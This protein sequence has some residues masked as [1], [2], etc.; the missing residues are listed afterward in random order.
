MGIRSLGRSVPGLPPRPPVPPVSQGWTSAP[1]AGKVVHW[2][3]AMI[4]VLT[5]AGGV[6]LILFGVRFLRKGLDRLFGARLGHWMRRLADRR[7]KAFLAGLG[8][9]IVA[10]SSTTVSVL[11]V[12]TVAA[13]HMTARQMLAVMFGADIGLTITV[14]LI[15]L[16]IEQYAPIVILP[17]VV[18]FQFCKR[19]PTRGIGQVLISLGMIFM[20]ID[21]IKQ[22]A[23]SVS[24]NEDLVRLLDIAAHYPTAMA[25]VAAVTALLLQSSTATIGLIIAL[26]MAGAID[27]A[28]A[29]PV[30]IGANVG[31]VLT[32]LAVGYG[33]ID[34]RRLALGNLLVKLIV[35]G[36]AIWLLEPA[37]E[38][39]ARIPGGLD[40]Q[41]AIGHTG[42]N[43]AVAMIGLPFVG[44]IHELTRRLI[45][46]P[47]AD[48]DHPFGPRHLTARP[49][50]SVAL[51]QSMREIMHAAE[52]VRQIFDDVWR[53]LKNNDPA[54][55]RQVSERDDQVDLLDQEIKRYLTRLVG[56]AGEADESG[57]QM[58]QLRYLNELET[59]GDIIDKNISELVIKKTTLGVKFSPDGSNELDELKAMVTEN[60]EIADTAFTTRSRLLAQ[61][62]MRHK[63]QVNQFEREMRDAH[64]ARL[65]ADLKESHE[66]SAIHL[67]LLIYLKRINSHVSHVA[68][69]ILQD[70][71]A[72]FPRTPTR[73]LDEEPHRR[74]R[75]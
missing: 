8:V 29:L 12:Q 30:V 46:E 4:T 62:L 55:A 42:F 36:I 59:I 61:Q 10:P 54:L 26:G 47:P 73:P 2:Q 60:L 3:I 14:A 39:L 17:G 35:A 5:I 9:S 34:T 75:T 69:A 70:T 68:Y 20:G 72:T 65:N 44:W 64:F 31:I 23:G 22:A 32:T 66:T 6:A 56:M 63:E 52:I 45:V 51:G 27:L 38:G 57:E 25:V 19:T 11:A 74:P 41:I 16:R 37:T 21:I 67:D 71:N 50:E 15:A 28:M 53:A 58:C 1:L 43:L 49:P 48:E 13:G 18:M 40:R 7:L 24:L 33:R